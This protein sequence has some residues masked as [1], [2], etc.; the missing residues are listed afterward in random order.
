MNLLEK[1]DTR[2]HFLM[3]QYVDA[4]YQDIKAF[5]EEYDIAFLDSKITLKEVFEKRNTLIN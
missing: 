3:V 2:Y 4:F 1:V 5:S